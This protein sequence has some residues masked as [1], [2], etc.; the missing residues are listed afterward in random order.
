MI[1]AGYTINRWQ[2]WLYYVPLYKQHYLSQPY[3]CC[4]LGTYLVIVLMLCGGPYSSQSCF[5]QSL[6]IELEENPFFRPEPVKCSVTL[7]LVP[8][9]GVTCDIHA[10]LGD[11]PQGWPRHKV[12]AQTW[13][14]LTSGGDTAVC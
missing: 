2:Q 1:A 13:C 9:L 14:L 7:W 4:H 11:P 8:I 3:N 6:E 10:G 5:C 12:Q